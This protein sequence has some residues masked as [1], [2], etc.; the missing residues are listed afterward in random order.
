MKVRAL[1]E[2]FIGGARRRKGAEFE[3][4]GKKLPHYL[5]SLEGKKARGEAKVV[6]E[7]ASTTPTGDQE[8]L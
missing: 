5:I 8:V 3:W 1:K 2:C 4:V 6:E 7:V